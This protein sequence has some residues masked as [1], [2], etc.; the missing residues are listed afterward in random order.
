[1]S[2][3]Q[4]EYAPPPT[5]S[6]PPSASPS[7]P[8]RRSC[9]S[10]ILGFIGWIFTLVLSVGLALAAVALIA[11]FAFGFTLQTPG[12]VNS[13][14]NEIAELRAANDEAN[15]RISDLQTQVAQQSSAGSDTNAQLGD[16][17]GRIGTI[18]TQVA[19]AEQQ[20]AELQSLGRDMEALGQELEENIALAA[21]LQAEARDDQ[22]AI[23]V[24]STVQAEN[25]LRLS[26]L[27]QKADRLTR[28]IERLGDIVGDTESDLATPVASTPTPAAPTSTS[29]TP[30]LPTVSSPTSTT[31]A[32]PTPTP[33][34]TP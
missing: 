24:F 19:L 16:L 9:L 34:A 31:T 17:D 23:A 5:Q 18:Q 1:M 8:P 15:A 22:V 32:I 12:Q 2:E 26:E 27:Q 10:Q 25:T 14:P 21:T 29:P 7:R 33:T 4:Q 28:F 30:G 6:L 20:A 13:V 3:P 11:Y